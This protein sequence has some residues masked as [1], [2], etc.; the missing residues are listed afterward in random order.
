M[1]CGLA[2]LVVGV[3]TGFIGVGGGFL[4]VPTMI[5]FARLPMPTAVGTSLAVIAANSVAGLAG[6]LWHDGFD[7]RTTLAFLA[8]ALLGML[9][10]VRLGGRVP[11][12][13]L[14]RAFGSLVLA[15]AGFVIA[16]N[17]QAFAF[18]PSLNQP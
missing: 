5:L 7:W 9:A 11:T 18:T 8:A 15:V 16:K 13:V 3:L 1:R 12:V 17:W 4:L 10:G 6:H 2:G 14:L